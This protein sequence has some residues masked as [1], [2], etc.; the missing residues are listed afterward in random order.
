MRPKAQR[1]ADMVSTDIVTV[2]E[3]ASVA[4]V[5]AVASGAKWTVITDAESRPVRMLATAELEHVPAVRSITSVEAGLVFVMPSRLP[6]DYVGRTSQVR[7]NVGG[8]LEIQG[9][10]TYD[11]HATSPIGVWAGP[12]LGHYLSL[13][14]ASHASGSW[15]PG[16]VDIDLTEHECAFTEVALICEFYLEFEELPDDMPP[17]DNPKHMTA[18]T[19]TW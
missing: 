12:S 4:D 3:T 11:E 18:H 6:I 14:T 17:C 19:F 8:L 16:N 2:P 7:R 15:L 1:L 5:R 9:I 10:V 13:L